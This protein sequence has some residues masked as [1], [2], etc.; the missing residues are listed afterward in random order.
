[1]KS[2]FILIIS[3]SMF[4]MCNKATE[5][6]RVQS[7]V[8]NTTSANNTNNQN[9]NGS[10]KAIILTAGFHHGYEL[11]KNEDAYKWFGV[12][13]NEKGYYLEETKIKTTK[14]FD[15]VNDKSNEKSGVTVETI[16]QDKSVLL[17]SGSGFLSDH[18]IEQATLASD[19]IAPGDTFS[20]NFH[21]NDYKLYVARGIKIIQ[22]EWQHYDVWNYIHYATAIKLYLSATK[23]GQPV[24]DLL[25]EKSNFDNEKINIIFSGDIDGDGFPDLIIDTSGRGN[26]INETLYLSKPASGNKLLKVVG[27]KMSVGC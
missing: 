11:R 6:S 4:A 1:M 8:E 20:F 24:T 23:N 25:L 19:A 22:D 26:T 2:R 5:I 9:E 16:N 27:E 7:T 12:F 10:D 14:V 17:I 18:K 15:P 21:G 3:A 13:E